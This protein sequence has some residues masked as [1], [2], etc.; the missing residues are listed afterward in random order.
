MSLIE[1]K[2][3]VFSNSISL[4]K[5]IESYKNSADISLKLP[6]AILKTAENFEQKKLNESCL[7]SET[8][9]FAVKIYL[10]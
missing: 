3:I 10:N 1:L 5:E 7:L 9:G 2:R 4:S 8:F 6:E